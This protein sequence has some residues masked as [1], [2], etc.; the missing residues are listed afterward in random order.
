[1]LTKETKQDREHEATSLIT[2]LL[3]T[4]KKQAKQTTSNLAPRNTVIKHTENALD[5][6]VEVNKRFF[7]KNKEGKKRQKRRNSPYMTIT[8]QNHTVIC[9]QQNSN[10]F[11][12]DHTYRAS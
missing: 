1:M 11:Y 10:T 8:Q 4:K 5:S 9:R 2:T 12:E 7:L 6:N 3:I